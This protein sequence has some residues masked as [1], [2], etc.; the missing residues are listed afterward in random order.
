VFGDAPD[1]ALAEPT[2]A[3]GPHDDQVETARLGVV[4]DLVGGVRLA[5]GRRDDVEEF[6]GGV[7]LLGDVEGVPRLVGRFPAAVSRDQDAVV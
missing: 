5:D 2:V 1:E 7:V 4:D 3:E 6:D